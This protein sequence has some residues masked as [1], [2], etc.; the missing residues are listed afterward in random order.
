MCSALWGAVFRSGHSTVRIP[1]WSPSVLCIFEESRSPT[2]TLSPAPPR[3]A[4]VPFRGAGRGTSHTARD[5]TLL[6]RLRVKLPPCKSGVP[7]I[8]VTLSLDIDGMLT[9]S[10]KRARASCLSFVLTG[11]FAQVS[12]HVRLPVSRGF[13]G[14]QERALSQGGGRTRRS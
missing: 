3:C 9:I 7:Q 5:C 12:A 13:Q 6:G 1:D 4:R 2:G 8:R 11:H 14:D 10:A